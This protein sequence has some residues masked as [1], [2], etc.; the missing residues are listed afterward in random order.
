ML[1]WTSESGFKCCYICRLKEPRVLGE[2]SVLCWG[3]QIKNLSL[4]LISKQRHKEETMEKDWEGLAHLM[5]LTNVR[6][7]K[8]GQASIMMPKEINNTK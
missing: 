1:F 6:R 8:K 4:E 2:E 7:A 5:L 3:K